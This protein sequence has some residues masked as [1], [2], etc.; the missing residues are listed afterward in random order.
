MLPTSKTY[1]YHKQIKI[2]KGTINEVI[3]LVYDKISKMTRV[4]ENDLS[5]RLKIYE[6]LKELLPPGK[7]KLL[8][9]Y[10]ELQ[11]KETD[12][13]LEK[14]ITFIIKNEKEISDTLVNY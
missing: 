11:V 8:L 3:N 10:E 6:E 5:K 12:V 13:V 7:Q 1:L 2:N 9:K 14:A 4:Q